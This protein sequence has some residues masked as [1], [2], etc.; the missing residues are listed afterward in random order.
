V[1]DRGEEWG[2]P[3][4]RIEAEVAA[5]G[6]LM[7]MGGAEEGDAAYARVNEGILDRALRFATGG[8]ER[9]GS[10]AVVAFVVWDGVSRGASDLTEQFAA[11]AR[12]RGLPVEEVRTDRRMSPA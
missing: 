11:A 12:K 3:Y 8:T 9:G 6:G 7:V 1:V 5:A 2:P 10:P 4:D